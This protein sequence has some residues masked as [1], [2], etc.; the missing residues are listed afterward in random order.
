MVYLVD[1][2]GMGDSDCAPYHKH[3]PKIQQHHHTGFH[4]QQ[5]QLHEKQHLVS[6]VK[7]DRVKASRSQL[8]VNDVAN[9]KDEIAIHP[10]TNQV[11]GH[12]RLLLLNQSTVIKP[13]NIRELDFYQ[14]IPQD[15][16]MF[17]PK[18]KGVLQATTTGGMKF[19]KRY[20][21]S[22]RDD[23][24][25]KNG[26][27]APKR[28]REDVLR[29]KI[30]K[31]GNA[32]DVIKSI[33]HIDNSNKQYYLMLENITSQ[34]RQPC[35]LDLK[36]GTR[37]HGDDASAEK[38]TKQIAKC[39]AST[40][41]SL[42]VRLCGMQVYQARFDQY[43]K[44]DKYFGR[45]LNEEGFKQ[46][47][48][49]F[50]HNGCVLRTSVIMKVIQRLAQLRRVIEKQSSYRFYSCSLL[51][52]YEGSDE[53]ASIDPMDACY[54]LENCC[55]DP[56]ETAS[57]VSCCYD[58]DASTDS[59]DINLSSSHEDEHSADNV[60][61]SVST[62]LHHR[63]FGEAAARGSF[64]P[65]SED[66]LDSS[67][68]Q[69]IDSSSP[70]SNDSWMNYSSHSSDDYSFLIDDVDDVSGADKKR[71][72]PMKNKRNR[73]ELQ[74]HQELDEDDEV[75]RA[76]ARILETPKRRRSRERCSSPLVDVR[77]IDFAHTTFGRKNS[78]GA[79]VNG[80]SSSAAVHHG[81]DCGFLTGLDSLKRLL[82]EIVKEEH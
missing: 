10:L 67:G 25:R 34:F 79:V 43:M 80:P 68:D 26:S 73:E 57:T 36:M 56:E 74:F 9:E 72:S 15:V 70:T 33:S 17:V 54:S 49:N 82:M 71:G 63:G 41:A 23:S 75:A 4:Q 39:A 62:D 20:S 3:G 81:P 45:E 11:G 24:T 19:D 58:A 76:E 53:I 59:V 40:S 42:G 35:I 60:A 29:M 64:I 31:N 22:F 28:K 47:L 38:R 1:S 18:Y 13:L 27:G 12:T 52:V 30:H 37:Q 7:N 50:F 66:A 69:M 8:A 46:A 77:I 5:Q 21:P 65:F 61:P 55:I 6:V 16:Q 2:W 51:V 44:K 32:A 48:S 78:A 14:N